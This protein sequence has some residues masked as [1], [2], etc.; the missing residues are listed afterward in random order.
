M[1]YEI[2]SE[3]FSQQID[4]LKQEQRDHIAKLYKP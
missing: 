2:Q 3:F 4:H 1:M